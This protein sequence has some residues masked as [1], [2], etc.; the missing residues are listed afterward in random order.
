MRSIAQYNLC[1]L[2]HIRVINNTIYFTGSLHISEH[3]S[4]VLEGGGGRAG[5]EEQEIG[6]GGTREKMEESKAIL[7]PCQTW[8]KQVVSRRV[9]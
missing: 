6:I 5:R 1:K 9:W 4:E 2:K 7:R 8:W 3:I